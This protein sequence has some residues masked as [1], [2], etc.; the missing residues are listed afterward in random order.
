[1]LTDVLVW[2]YPYRNFFSFLIVFC[3]NPKQ[4]FMG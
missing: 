3:S 4:L 2:L 1:M